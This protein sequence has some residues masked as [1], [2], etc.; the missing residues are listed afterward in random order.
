[1]A[2][3]KTL[4]DLQEQKQTQAAAVKN[5]SGVQQ[6]SVAAQSEPVSQAR[7]MLRQQMDKKPGAYSSAYRDQLEAMADKILNH[8]AFSY[9]VNAD[10]L[11][12]QMVDQY[13]QQGR[14]AMMDTMGQAQTMTGGYGNSYAQS[15]GQQA[16]QGYLRQANEQLPQ[17]Y[18][19][20][21]DRYDRE[22][23]A[24]RD[25]YALLLGQEEQDYSRYRDQLSDYYARLDR[26]QNQYNAD[27]DYEYRKDRDEIADKQWQAEFDE[28]VRQYNYKNGIRP[29]TSGGSATNG[30]SSYYDHRNQSQETG[31][32]IGEGRQAEIE[33]WVATSLANVTSP[34]FSLDRLIKGTSFLRSQEER[35]YATAVG[36]YIAG[37]S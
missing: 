6:G 32:G 21:L 1:M 3:Y 29:E 18:A 23:G 8:G 16:Y 11:Y 37:I 4:K 13:A 2:T 7:S 27:R 14:L 19:M 5:Q 33:N 30:G 10:A 31:S 28:A 20:A 12:Q 9:D 24:L 25:A 15:A 26:M 34:S 36:K 22:Q 17:F 35:D